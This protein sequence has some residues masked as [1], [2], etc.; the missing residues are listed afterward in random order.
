M[1]TFSVSAGD[2]LRLARKRL[3][4]IPGGVEKALVRAVNRA[5][6]QS[7]TA[8]VRKAAEIYTAKGKDVRPTMAVK[9]ATASSPEATITSRGPHLGLEHF[10]HRP[11]KDTTGAKRRRI[12]VAVKR[13]GGLKPLGASFVWQ[14]KIFRRKTTKS[15]PVSKLSGPSVPEML[16]NEEVREAVE[17]TA[18]EVIARRIDHEAKRL[19]EKGK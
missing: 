10:K 14:G 5:A 1:K 15:L 3:A 12:R 16:G 6:A 19:L 9:K 18:N 8:A 2:A 7:K 4:G 17:T 13:E 11:T